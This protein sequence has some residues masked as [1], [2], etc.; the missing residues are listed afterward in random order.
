M[1]FGQPRI[2]NAAFAS[3]FYKY[4]PDTFRIV[5]DR[6]IVPHL[7]PYYSF[8]WKSY[9]HFPREVLPSENLIHFVFTFIIFGTCWFHYDLEM[10][11]NSVLSIYQKKLYSWSI[12][13]EKSCTRKCDFLLETSKG[14]NTTGQVGFELGQVN[15]FQFGPGLS[16]I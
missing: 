3:C 16:L 2:G 5:H 12:S 13:Q 11:R 15:M 4:I 10:R 7:P 9:H 6:D 1:T 8:Y 14:V